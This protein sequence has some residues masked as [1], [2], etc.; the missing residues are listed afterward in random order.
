MQRS[1]N[2]L[3]PVSLHPVTLCSVTV[4]SVIE[5]GKTPFEVK[6]TPLNLEGYSPIT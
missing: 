5:K 1:V 3:C 4:S 6:Y 2:R